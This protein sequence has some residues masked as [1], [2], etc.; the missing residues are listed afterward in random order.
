[1]QLSSLERFER[2]TGGLYRKLSLGQTRRMDS[3]LTQLAD[4]LVSHSTQ[5]KA[6]ERVLI[7]AFD[8]PREAIEAVIERVVAAGAIP[9]V[10]TKDTRILSQLY[11]AATPDMMERWASWELNRMQQMDAYI[12]MRGSLNALELSDVPSD[13]MALYQ[14]HLWRGVH[15]YRVNHTRWVVLR[16]PTPA[17]AQAAG[18]STAAFEDFYFKVCTLDYAKMH[19]AQQPLKKRMEVADRVRLTGKGTDLTFSIKGIGAVTCSGEKNIPD[20]EI[21]SCPVLESV[22]G[23]IQ[24]NTPT[25][26]QGV[27]F[28]GIRLEFK[29]GK[30]VDATCS[31]DTKRLNEILDSDPGARYVGEFAIGFNPYVTRPML[32]ILFDEKIAG[33]FHFTPGQAYEDAGNGNKS[34]VHWDMVFIQTPEYGGGEIYFDDTLIRRDGV[35]IP[36]DLHALNP[37]NLM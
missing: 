5:L 15:N 4:V 22:N 14:E 19:A 35:F 29:D 11:Q 33:S 2:Y 37:E 25:L 9:F 18:M 3:R 24:Y 8:I 1:V 20:G 27:R 23:V 17:F 21:Y 34:G 13:R 28:E 7:E 30:I 36:E 32:D 12:G 6:G 26:Y 16:Y 10:E 31:T